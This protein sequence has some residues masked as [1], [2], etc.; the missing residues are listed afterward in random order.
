V[1]PEESEVGVHALPEKEVCIEVGLG[2]RGIILKGKEKLMDQEHNRKGRERK[3][4]DALRGE[5]G[6]KKGCGGGK[7]D[8]SGN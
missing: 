5:A 2:G 1:V 4:F 6:L 8:N 3:S 7:K